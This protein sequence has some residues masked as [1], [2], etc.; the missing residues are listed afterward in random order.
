MDEIKVSPNVFD[1]LTPREAD[2]F[3]LYLID[4]KRLEDIA[5][6]FDMDVSVVRAFYESS[7]QKVLREFGREKEFSDWL[8]WRPID[9]I[10]QLADK[11]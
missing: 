6:I 7:V 8:L 5:I 4:R 10:P 1:K 9:C 11:S 3:T 2:I